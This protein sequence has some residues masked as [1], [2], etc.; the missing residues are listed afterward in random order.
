MTMPMRFDPELYIRTLQE[1][2]V[3]PQQA[4]AHAQALSDVLD[5]NPVATQ[6]DLVILKA[7]ILAQ[8][9]Q[10]FDEFELRIKEW[11]RDELGA[12]LAPLERRVTRLERMF[13]LML[14]LQV[15]QLAATF[16]GLAL[17]LR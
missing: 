17:L 14:V 5:T 1:G 2:G 10:M 12:R 16:G 6:A 3:P 15:V 11:V 8:V 4:I 7:E 9:Q 13:V